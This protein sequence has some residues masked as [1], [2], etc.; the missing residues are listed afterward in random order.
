MLKVKVK[1]REATTKILRVS[2][3][4]NSTHEELVSQLIFI[5]QTLQREAFLLP[6]CEK[7]ENHH[8]IMVY[9]DFEVQIMQRQIG[10]NLLTTLDAVINTVCFFTFAMNVR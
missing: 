8:L 1:M 6:V 3:L 2:K 7:Q 4:T 9:V 5:A 10:L